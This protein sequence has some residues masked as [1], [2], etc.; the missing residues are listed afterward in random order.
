MANQAT[1]PVECTL[2]MENKMT[3]N[4]HNPEG[5]SGDDGEPDPGPYWR[6]MHRDWRFWVGAIL[7][8]AALA[9][10]VLSGDLAWVPRGN[11]H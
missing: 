5:H 6:R 11:S 2:T 8:G 10:F 3:G 7:M 4:K 9:I 1:R